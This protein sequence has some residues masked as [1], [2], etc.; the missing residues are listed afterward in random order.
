MSASQ[1]GETVRISRIPWQA[2]TTS[3][4]TLHG[5]SFLI[6]KKLENTND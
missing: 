4:I 2:L 3:F 1:S 5:P 6:L